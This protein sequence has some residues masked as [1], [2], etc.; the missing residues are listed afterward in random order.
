MDITTKL[1]LTATGKRKSVRFECDFDQSYLYIGL[2]CHYYGNER[3]QVR[4]LVIHHFSHKSIFHTP[5]GLTRG[6]PIRSVRYTPSKMNLEFML[7]YHLKKSLT[8]ISFDKISISNKY[9]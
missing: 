7:N 8:I 9:V 5:Y 6:G 2:G 3:A 1:P 4:I